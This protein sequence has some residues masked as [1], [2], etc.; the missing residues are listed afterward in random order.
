MKT[1]QYLTFLFTLF[2]FSEFCSGQSSELLWAQNYGE[3][4]YDRFSASVIGPSGA[5]YST[6]HYEGLVDFD[7]G[8][9]VFE[10]SETGN[11]FIQK[12]DADGELIWAKCIDQTATFPPLFP[13]NN[14]GGG[15]ASDSEENIIVAGSFE[16]EIDA[17]PGPEEHLLTYNG[18]SD[19]F[20]QKMD[21]D[22][23]FLWAHNIGGTNVD[24]AMGVTTDSDDNI[25]VTGVFSEEV[26]F[27]PDPDNEIF[28]S[29][30]TSPP[31]TFVVKL[32]P[33]GNVLWAAGFSGNFSYPID[34]VTDGNND[35][36]LTGNFSGDTD[37]DP[38]AGVVMYPTINFDAYVLK[39]DTEGGFMWVQVMDGGYGFSTGRA[40]VVDNSNHIYCAGEFSGTVDFDM[41]EE[42]YILVENG[43]TENSTLSDCFIEKLS[44][45]GDLIWAKQVGGLGSDGAWDLTID[46]DD[47]QH[48]GLLMTGTFSLTTDF[49]PNEGE[50]NLTTQGVGG[51]PGA[52]SKNIFIESLNFDGEFLWAEQIDNSYGAYAA[53]ILSASNGSMVISG[54]FYEGVDPDFDLSDDEDYILSAAG[55]TDSFIAKYDLN[56]PEWNFSMLETELPDVFSECELNDLTAPLAIN[57]C[58]LY[59]PGTPDISL[60]LT[61]DG[62]Y[63]IEWTFENSDGNMLNQEQ[64]I[65]ISLLSNAASQVED[66]LMATADGYSYQW[67]DCDDGNSPVPGATSQTFYPESGGNYAVEIS[68]TEGCTRISECMSYIGLS[69]LE[70]EFASGLSIYPNPGS[71]DVNIDFSDNQESIRVK[72]ISVLG[73]IVNEYSYTNTSHIEFFIEGS[74]AWYFIEVENASGAMYRT[75]ILKN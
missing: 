64:N 27:D 46:N 3:S 61:E 60:P 41:T 71:G 8:D 5:I 12:L 23:N 51:T 55:L 19:I 52:F 43:S 2:G 57:G 18:V 7:P 10:L 65:N 73:E 30:D 50:F 29:P 34:L 59:F 31:G 62:N 38:G 35:L 33:D 4:S 28:I 24:I 53:S 72:I 63:T 17:D 68:N 22:G 45:E 16:G 37:F 70:N 13:G 20:I 36:I 26:D 69:L 9:G 11:I 21:A 15:I 14:Y 75:K 39:L 56:C 54:L 44:P 67:V 40:L 48:P 58:G 74:A 42:T 6:G 49:N 47:V 1:I 66:Y 25:Y 32:D